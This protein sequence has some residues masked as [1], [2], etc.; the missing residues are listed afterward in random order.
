MNPALVQR[1]AALAG[2][3]LLGTL[4]ALALTQAGDG[5]APSVGDT[6][7]APRVTWEPARAS[8]VGPEQL[9]RETSC[10]ITLTRETLGVAHPVLPCGVELVLAHGGQEVQVEVVEQGNVGAGVAFELTPALARQL[11][12][13][14]TQVVRW[15]FAPA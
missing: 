12:V 14:G 15:R 1:Q 4:G 9:G 2:V 5:A 7:T 10:G 3:A 6:S 13:R 8:I 11:G